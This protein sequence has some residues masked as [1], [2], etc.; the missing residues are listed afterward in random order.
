MS[1][2][3]G[4]IDSLKHALLK[5]STIRPGAELLLEALKSEIPD[6]TLEAIRY[7][8]EDILAPMYF[9]IPTL[10]QFWSSRSSARRLSWLSAKVN[11][12]KTS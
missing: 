12:K 11:V 1:Y 9:T 10:S 6:M 4:E 8:S 3:E 7:Q 5:R 2:S